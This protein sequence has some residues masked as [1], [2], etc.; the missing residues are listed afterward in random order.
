MEFHNTKKVAN[1][2]I[3]QK[4]Q[5]N[6][7]LDE[8]SPII[9]TSLSDKII[10]QII[11]LISRKVLKPGQRLPSEKELCKRFG[12]GR[13]SIREALRSLAVVG[14]LDGRVGEG[15]FVSKNNQRYFERNLHWGLLL[16]RKKVEDLIEIRLMLETQTAFSA[17]QKATQTNL[18][19]MQ[20]TILGMKVS[21]DKP[22]QYLEF[23]LKFHLLVAE[24]T[25][26][27]ILYHLVT[28]TRSYL[29][30]WIKESLDDPSTVKARIRAESSI[31]EHQ[32]IL[33]A[34]T[35]HQ[36]EKALKAMREHI[37]SSSKDLHYHI[38]QRE[39]V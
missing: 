1:G 36:A 14:I 31:Q 20:E 22:S 17:A 19:S 5:N 26:N 10:E 37:L 4:S 8:V 27:S 30:E 35:I 23:D 28:M 34:I 39:I 9:R 24:A 29:Q 32:E 33:E 25:Q 2:L 12:V 7:S 3:N 38:E 15:T 16:D 11:D 18:E 6:E 21:I 13:T